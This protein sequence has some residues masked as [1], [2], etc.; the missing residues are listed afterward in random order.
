MFR[1]GSRAAAISKMECFVIIVNGFQLLSI[2]TKHSILNVAAALD[3]PLCVFHIET[4][5]NKPCHICNKKK[6][7]EQFVF[8]M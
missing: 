8:K 5:I 3:P 1:E 7:D 2:I 4:E 6:E